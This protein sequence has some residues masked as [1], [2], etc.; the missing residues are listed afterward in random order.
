MKGPFKKGVPKRLENIGLFV[1]I[2]RLNPSFRINK[3]P[4]PEPGMLLALAFGMR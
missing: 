3:L 2:C 4:E 1:T